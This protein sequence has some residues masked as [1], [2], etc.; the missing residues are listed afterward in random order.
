MLAE[1]ALTEVL[2]ILG[3]IALLLAIIYLVRR[4]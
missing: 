1:I 2:V 4:A 3:I